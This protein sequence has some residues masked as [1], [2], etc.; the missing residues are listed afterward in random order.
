MRNYWTILLCSF[1][2]L[3]GVSYAQSPPLEKTVEK[4]KELYQEKRYE[5]ALAATLE[6]LPLVEKESGPHS[7][8]VA[9]FWEAIGQLYVKTQGLR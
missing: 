7:L 5:E 3:H 2:L 6:A 4:I 8:Q 1:L 9:R